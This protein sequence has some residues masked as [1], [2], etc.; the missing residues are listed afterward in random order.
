MWGSA[1][2][3]TEEKSVY[4]SCLHTAPTVARPLPRN[5]TLPDGEAWRTLPDL[6]IVVCCEF[7]SP[8][9]RSSSK[10]AAEA[11]HEN[12]EEGVKVCCSDERGQGSED[13]S[14]QPHNSDAVIEAMVGTEVN[15]VGHVGAEYPRPITNG[16]VSHEAG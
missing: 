4:R 7:Y 11:Q 8:L 1:E 3:E 9:P 10:S 6:A 16:L 13:L 2:S 12:L 15:L 14:A 5:V